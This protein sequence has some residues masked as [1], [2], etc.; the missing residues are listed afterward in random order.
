MR[1]SDYL[2]SHR[3]D[4]TRLEAFVREQFA[5]LPDEPVYLTGSLVE[6]LGNRRSDLDVYLLT[7][8]GMPSTLINGSMAIMALERTTVDLEV[9]SPA[10]VDALLARL[11]SLPSNEMRDQRVSAT[12]FAP[13]EL[14]FLHNLRIGAPIC[15]EDAFR[16]IASQV[17][18]RRLAR[19]L[20]DHAVA[21]IN[22][23][24]VDILG[25]IEDRDHASARHLLHHYLG[26][27]AA[28]FLAANGNTNP[29]EKWR[30]RKLAGL[31]LG[32]GRAAMPGG[33][34][35]AGMAR[36][37][38]ALHIA[39]E[40]DAASV[41]REFGRIARMGHA[42]IPWGQRRF[43]ENAALEPQPEPPEDFPPAAHHH[44][45][46]DATEAPLE[47]L[48]LD[49]HLRY[50]GNGDYVLTAIDDGTTLTLNESGYEL[51]LRFDGR[52]S[53]REAV[54]SLAGLTRASPREMAGTLDDF[55]LLLE[56]R[57]LIQPL[58]S[59]VFP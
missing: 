54:R 19:L 6:G 5:P 24:H 4:M 30:V 41:R 29:A 14:K 18:G 26:H 23:L 1:L 15:N 39:C 12:A 34:S 36:S 48:E 7:D 58:A 42:I 9:I 3:L 33:A 47:P 8:R 28:A 20:F 27:L 13:A 52:T 37:F 38:Q 51:L 2:R 45:G 17:E 16:R 50:A 44:S 21:W 35:V 31:A 53:R 40:A 46:H 22:S 57:G 10:R 25:L 32:G 56:T 43:L 49:C 55:Q 59:E 11:A